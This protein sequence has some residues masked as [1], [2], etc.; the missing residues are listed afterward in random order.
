MDNVPPTR[1]E[2]ERIWNYAPR[3]DIPT[4]LDALYG[5]LYH[6]YSH[7]YAGTWQGITR[8]TEPMWRADVPASTAAF[9]IRMAKEWYMETGLIDATLPEY[10][11]VEEGL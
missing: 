6:D 11:R 2:I 5:Q 7:D 8:S 1:D 10:L 9:G 4:R 3:Q